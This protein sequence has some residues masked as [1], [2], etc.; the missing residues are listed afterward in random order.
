MQ[1]RTEASTASRNEEVTTA[2]DFLPHRKSQLGIPTSRTN[3]IPEN[4]TDPRHPTCDAPFASMNKTSRPSFRAKYANLVALGGRDDWEQVD[5]PPSPREEVLAKQ[6]VAVLL[7]THCAAH[8]RQP[9]Q[10]GYLTML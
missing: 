9:E 2:L 10:I 6:V 1:Q 7:N 8:H 4:Q 3:G 5:H